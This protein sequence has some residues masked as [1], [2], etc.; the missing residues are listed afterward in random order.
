MPNGA[1]LHSVLM[2]IE[3]IFKVDRLCL[4]S[5][6]GHFNFCYI[7][8]TYEAYTMTFKATLS[9]TCSSYWKAIRQLV[10]RHNE[11]LVADDV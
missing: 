9:Q 2:D 6:S 10:S 1:N 4:S 3:F 8:I 5:L 11:Q 7:S